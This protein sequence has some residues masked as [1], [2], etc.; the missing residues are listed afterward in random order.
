MILEV[1]TTKHFNEVAERL[2]NE[3]I[4]KLKREMP[5]YHK[6]LMVNKKEMKRFIDII[7]DT[8]KEYFYEGHDEKSGYCL[9]RN[10]NQIRA[11]EHLQSLAFTHSYLYKLMQ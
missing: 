6:E 11:R 9:F 5:S 4:N 10:V 3:N 7:I 2:F 8:T 1:K